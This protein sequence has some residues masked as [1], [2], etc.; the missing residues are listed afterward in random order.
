[1]RFCNAS[2]CSRLSNTK[3]QLGNKKLPSVQIEI[4]TKARF[5]LVSSCELQDVKEYHRKP[6]GPLRISSLRTRAGPLKSVPRQARLREKVMLLIWVGYGNL[7]PSF[8][9]F[10]I[11]VS[12]HLD[13]TFRV[14]FCI[15]TQHSFASNQKVSRPRQI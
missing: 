1:M 12:L 13:C 10:L 8:S 7:Y 11:S 4:N 3:P 6:R 15:F 2:G 14:Y 5:S 9:V